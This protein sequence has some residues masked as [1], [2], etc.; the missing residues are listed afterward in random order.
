MDMNIDAG[1]IRSERLKRAW[2]QEHLAQVSGLG[3]RTVQR[4]ENGENASLETIKALAAVLE[5][6]V[7]AILVQSLPQATLMV[8]PT[9]SH[10][11]LFKPWRTFVAG[12]A[13]AAM[14]MGSLFNMQGARA[15]RVAMDFDVTLDGEKLAI[16]PLSTA[17]G[18]PVALEIRDLFRIKLV[19][20]ITQSRM[21]L[22]NIEIYAMTDGEYKLLARPAVTMSAGSPA[23]IKSGSDTGAMLEVR[24]TPTIE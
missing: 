23:L 24:L 10:L 12:C 11:S 9:R 13:V 21:V 6:P 20:T 8:S 19:P 7:E 5:L 17:D 18:S 2:S 1:L 15:E 16:D 14:V 22:V 4:I 3:L